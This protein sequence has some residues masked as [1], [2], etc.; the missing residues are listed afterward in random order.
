MLL[1]SLLIHAKLAWPM[2]CRAILSACS[3]A[4]LHATGS[5]E[6]KRLKAEAGDA[7]LP[8]EPGEPFPC[9]VFAG[10]TMS[11]VACGECGARSEVTERFVDLSLNIPVERLGGEESEADWGSALPWGLRSGRATNLFTG[12]GS[13]ESL[14]SSDGGG[15]QSSGE[16]GEAEE[17]TVEECLERFVQVGGQTFLPH[18]ARTLSLLSLLIW[19]SPPRP[20]SSCLFLL[21]YSRLSLALDISSVY[22]PSPLSHF[23]S[24]SHTNMC[25]KT[26]PRTPPSSPPPLFPSSTLL[27]PP[28]PF[29]PPSLFPSSPLPLFS[30]PPPPT[31]SETTR[32][33][34]S[35]SVKPPPIPQC[36]ALES[37]NGSPVW[38]CIKCVKSR[39]GRGGKSTKQVQVV[40][41][42]E[43]L[44][45]H[46]KRFEVKGCGKV[47]KAGTPI[48]MS[49]KRE[50]PCT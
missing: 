50:Q 2:I 46:I 39:G 1:Q 17:C 3:Q 34:P 27:L 32:P 49:H 42:P 5:E 16:A 23:Q 8:R 13:D 36:E 9:N 35:P 31:H 4:L 10:K 28:S 26:N 11:T 15:M 25:R 18:P 33:P 41:L 22:F 48:K 40:S 37:Q 21:L 24:R 7:A 20:L 30:S 19:F 6:E 12:G 47:R 14:V 29:F 44:V 45:L 38:S 43:C